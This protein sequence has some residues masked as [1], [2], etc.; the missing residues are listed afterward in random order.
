MY[1][2]QK[3][4]SFNLPY[5]SIIGSNKKNP[6][7]R[8]WFDLEK[9]TYNCKGQIILHI[10]PRLVRNLVSNEGWNEILNFIGHRLKKFQL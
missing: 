9:F 6:P 3:Y 7:C 4:E 2:F 5:L 10:S 1:I 8:P